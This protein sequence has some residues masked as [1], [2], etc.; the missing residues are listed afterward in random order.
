MFKFV[1]LTGFI[2]GV[3]RYLQL[4]PRMHKPWMNIGSLVALSLACFGMTLVGNFQVAI[5]YVLYLLI[6]KKYLHS[7]GRCASVKKVLNVL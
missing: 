1:I 3:L 6:L 7:R 2:L 5:H 4:K